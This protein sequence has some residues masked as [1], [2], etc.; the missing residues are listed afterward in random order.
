MANNDWR[1]VARSL[2]ALALVA[3]T[4]CGS[5]ERALT[6]PAVKDSLRSAGAGRVYVIPK[7]D[8]DYVQVAVDSDL[9]LVR[10]KTLSAAEGV[11]SQARWSYRRAAGLGIVR[12]CNV[13]IYNL[14][15]DRTSART[16]AGRLAGSIKTRCD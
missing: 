4:G 14:A 11:F 8:L 2:T 7:G 10:F 9:L 16:R 15:A 3:S 6:L 1:L 13:L 12:A 5:D